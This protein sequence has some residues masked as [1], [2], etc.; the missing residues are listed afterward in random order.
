MVDSLESGHKLR[1]YFT[2]RE[3]CESRSKHVVQAF[4]DVVVN[5]ET[6]EVWDKVRNR[7]LLSDDRISVC[8][9]GLR[10]FSIR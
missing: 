6:M 10:L 4:V 8:H 1:E 7:F 3:V 5:I 9:C 2:V